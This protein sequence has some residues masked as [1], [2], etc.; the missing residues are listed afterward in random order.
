LYLILGAGMGTLTDY[1]VLR[2]NAA[3]QEAQDYGVHAQL[4]AHVLV[5]EDTRIVQIASS[6]VAD[7]H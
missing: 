5:E 7:G 6:G 4:H 3:M 1:I 2:W